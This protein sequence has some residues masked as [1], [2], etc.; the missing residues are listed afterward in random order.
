MRLRDLPTAVMVWTASQVHS[1]LWPRH[2]VVTATNL[3]NRLPNLKVAHI[4]LD[5]RTPKA[6]DEGHLPRAVN[7]AVSD[8]AALLRLR[9][10]RGS[11]VFI[12]AYDQDGHTIS[13]IKA[14]LRGAG[15]SNVSYLRGG[16]AAWPE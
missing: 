3:A 7:V 1:I 5:L 11:S 10:D 16:Y 4:I 6:Y 12:I 2:E 9:K 13:V 8:A 15:F 14:A